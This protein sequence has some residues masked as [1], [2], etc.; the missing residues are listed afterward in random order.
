MD[1]D[2]LRL[3]TGSSLLLYQIWAMFLKK[4]IYTIRN[5]IT[6]II[7]FLIPPVFLIMTMAI[8]DILAGNKNLP[9]LPISMYKYLKTVT[10]LQKDSSPE[11]LEDI[12]IKGYQ[13][14]K[15]FKDQNYRLDTTETEIQEYILNRVIS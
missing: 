3:K 2:K 10:V 7:Q 5:L 6:L 15:V 8:E 14:L 1:L 9:E 13:S 11:G 12:A 4:S